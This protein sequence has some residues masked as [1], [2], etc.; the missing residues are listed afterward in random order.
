MFQFIFDK[1]GRLVRIDRVQRNDAHTGY[2]SVWTAGA[3]LSRDFTS[4]LNLYGESTLGVSSASK[5]SFAGTLGGGLT[6]RVSSGIS[7]EFG[8]NRGFGARSLE[9]AATAF[10]VVL[11]LQ[12]VG[13]LL[14]GR[15]VGP[16]YWLTIVLVGAG[17]AGCVWVGSLARALLRPR[18]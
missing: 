10:A 3:Y 5:S 18:R 6:L 15:E 7:W 17:W 1:A 16:Q 8:L 9:L 4:H 2:D 11:A 12:T 14:S 13:L